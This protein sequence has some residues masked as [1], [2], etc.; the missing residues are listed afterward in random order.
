MGDIETKGLLV[1]LVDQDFG[2]GAD[3][4]GPCDDSPVS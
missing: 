3:L 1:K 4:C 2:L